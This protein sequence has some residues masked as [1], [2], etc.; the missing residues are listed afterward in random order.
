MSQKFTILFDLDGTLVDTA[1]DLIIAHNHVM[2]KFGY[3]SKS[4]EEIKSLVSKGAETLI[5]KSIWNT[6][7]KEFS[8]IQDRKKKDTIVKEFINFY[9]ENIYVESKLIAGA[10]SF[11]KWCKSNNISSAVCTNKEEHLAIN[12]LKKIGIYKYLEYV[13]GRNTFDYCKPD[14]RH[15]TSIIEILKGDIKKTIMIGDSEID[16]TAAE[17]ASIPFVLLE[18]GYTNKNIS[19]I[20]HDHLIKDFNGTEKIIQK[21]LND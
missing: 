17:N 1:P 15:L 6:A 21:Y 3:K 20:K 5:S 14:P 2:K 16:S 12:L 9:A 13:A 7:K 8:Q 11:L 18:D 4:A 10:E 19:Q